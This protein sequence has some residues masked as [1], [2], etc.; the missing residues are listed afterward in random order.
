MSQPPPPPSYPLRVVPHTYLLFNTHT[1]PGHVYLRSDGS[2]QVDTSLVGQDRDSPSF[3]LLFRFL[4]S[5]F[6]THTLFNISYHNFV[7][8][9]N[10]LFLRDCPRIPFFFPPSLF[11]FSNYIHII[12]IYLYIYTLTHNIYIHTYIIHIVYI[13]LS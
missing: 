3:L 2:H 12:Y 8:L 4:L 7:I 6:S 13:S 10:R 1:H 11:L 5:S 9:E